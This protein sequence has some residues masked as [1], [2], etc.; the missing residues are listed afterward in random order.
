LSLLHTA[1]GSSVV[2]D[3]VYLTESLFFSKSPTYKDKIGD[4]KEG[5][6]LAGDKVSYVKTPGKLAWC[7]SLSSQLRRRLRQEDF[8]FG[9]SLGNLVSWSQKQNLFFFKEPEI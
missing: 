4:K 1:S 8:K 2:S 9:A 7:C 3:L 6:P 5:K